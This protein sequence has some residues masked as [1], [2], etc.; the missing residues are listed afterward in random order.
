MVQMLRYGVKPFKQLSLFGLL[1][2]AW[3]L[4]AAPLD[5]DQVPL[6]TKNSA[7]A[8]L[9]LAIDDSGSMDWESL[10]DTD[11]GLFWW[12][13]TSQSFVGSGKLNITGGSQIGYIFP[14]GTGTGNRTYTN[15]YGLAPLPQYAFGRSV[16]Y[17]KMY[18]DPNITYTPW[19]S[20]GSTTFG[21]VTPSSAPSD[22]VAGSSTMD[23]TGKIQS[24]SSNWGFFVGA[25]TRLPVGTEYVD[26]VWNGWNWVWAW[27]SVSGSQ[28]IVATD[29]TA[30]YIS[31]YPA[32]YYNEAADGTSYTVNGINGTCS[33]S[34]PTASHYQIF[35][36]FPGS[37]TGVDALGSDGRCL[38]EVRVRSGVSSYTHNGNRTDCASSS[39]C[40]YAEEIQNFAN[41]W[42]YY[43]K[44]HQTLRA[45]MG[46]ALNGISSLRAGSFTI[47]G[48]ASVTMRDMSTSSDVTAL[49]DGLYSI[50]GTSN[51]TPN[52]E[53][54][55]HAGQQFLRTNSGAPVIEECQQNF[56]LLFTDGYSNT[57]TV[58][59][60]NIQDDSSE[61]TPYGDS[62]SDSTLGDI[63]MHYYKTNL[64]TD[65][66]PVG[67]V[68][69]N[70][71]CKATTPD[72]KLDCN[73]N[74]HMNTYSVGLGAAGT[75][76]GVTHNTTADAYTTT[77]TWP[78]MTVRDRRQIDDLYHAALNGR[79]EIY[80]ADSATEL[81]SKL[82]NAFV[83]IQAKLGS[84]SAVTF[85]TATLEANSAVY[86]ALFNSANWS[87]DLLSFELDA[88]G[89][90]AAT[91]TWSAASELADG[92]PTSNT[93]VIV[94][95]DGSKGVPF[96][97][98]SLTTA[99]QSDFN[100]LAAGGI[101]GTDVLNYIR[102]DRTNEVA[103]KLRIRDSV[104][105]D[106]ISGSPVYVGKPALKWPSSAP[107][108]T[109]VGHRYSDFIA[110]QQASPRKAVVY[111]GGNDGMLH[112]FDAGTDGSTRG[113][114]LIGYVPASVYSTSA[115]AGLHYLA[116]PQYQH[117]YY[118]DLAPTVSDVYIDTTDDSTANPTWA[119]VLLGGLRG[120]GKSLFL[121]DITNPADFS[122]SAANAEKLALWEFSHAE[123]GYTYSKPVIA[124]MENGRWAAIFGN[125]Y[126]N[127]GTGKA[128]LFIVFLDGGLDG[129]WTNGSDYI[130]LD[131]G[132]GSSTT[133]NGLATPRVIDL[134]GNGA[135]D[136]VY[137]GDLQG[138]MW[139]FD[140]SNTTNTS[141]WDV[142]YKTGSTP[143]PL[144]TAK[145][146]SGNAQ[147]ITSRPVIRRHPSVT[148]KSTGGG[149]N[150]PNLLVG[151][152]TGKFLEVVD[153]TDTSK[154]TF[155]GVWDHGDSKLL[156][157]SLV[158]QTIGTVTDTNTNTVYRT[159]T[160]NSVNYS[161]KDGW[162]IDLPDS[163]E[164][165]IVDPVLRGT[166]VFFNTSVPSP[167]A[168]AAGGSGYLM[169]ADFETGGA[170]SEA[171]FDVDGN[172]EVNA[173][174]SLSG[175]NPAGKTF[176]NGLPSSS[177]FLGNK[178]YTPGTDGDDINVDDVQNLDGL[179]TGRLSWQELVP[180]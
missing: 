87:G 23:L 90:I 177:R 145:D 21:N 39:S 159:L 157:G 148:T 178:V 108:P 96:R 16:L 93:R 135:A 143:D 60:T 10:A 139:A 137:A 169:A 115:Q 168:C 70:N 113:E 19:V 86:L 36:D 61:P 6:F 85:N 119:T 99:Q 163:G 175:K 180:D 71:G 34:S 179:Q 176:T 121:L 136:R 44:R 134:N 110:A 50:S 62:G 74:L 88:F 1:L 84:S 67:K 94:T 26:W 122:E 11:D 57:S 124:M 95:H 154:Q 51:G 166:L 171:A 2:V 82:Q 42:S 32:T 75:V 120:G 69:V 76:Y 129:T 91:N 164:R 153:M 101:S 29:D 104:L 158:Q 35:E 167:D 63:A 68:P 78:D 47:N 17:N 12:N 45:G 79:G 28:I 155:Y 107:F 15:R 114:E 89:N 22:P 49:Y 3:P 5:L 128:S 7:K 56:G 38:V 170:P 116:D 165:Q 111:I 48:R 130:V 81:Q 152:G 146:S 27:T 140:L 9:I 109:V 161:N 77:P 141:N 31:Y 18:Y 112:G 102:G 65:L 8:N 100:V 30:R 64:R 97:W 43:R 173:F 103:G 162:Y 54:L 92:A 172:G 33:S 25:G 37:I 40:T 52:R 131:T 58:S 125:G 41:W 156:R 150:E 46:G 151:F 98:G 66:T 55:N 144:F 13:S 118:V 72:A 123:L 83:S 133:P 117:R 106:I 138:N 14:N 4:L 53:A 127:S 126:N 24:S 80:N 132:V 59:I 20:N 142:A 147:P 174:D 105:G 73:I 160:S 149:A